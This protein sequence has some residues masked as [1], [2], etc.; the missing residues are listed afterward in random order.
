VHSAKGITE[1]SF[2]D[3]AKLPIA[4]RVQVAF[5][6][7]TLTQLA[8]LGFH[9]EQLRGSVYVMRRDPLES[10]AEKLSNRSAVDCLTESGREHS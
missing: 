9:C 10:F 5:N 7:Q 3:I 6:Q 1:M 8:G 4:S 2:E